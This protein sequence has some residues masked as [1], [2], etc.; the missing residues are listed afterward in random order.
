MTYQLKDQDVTPPEPD[1]TER[2][3][4][5]ADGVAA[6]VVAFLALGLIVLVLSQVVN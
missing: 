2:R 5:A 3:S 1:P 6:V 4:V